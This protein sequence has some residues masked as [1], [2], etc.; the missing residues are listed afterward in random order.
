[1]KVSYFGSPKRCH[2]CGTGEYVEVLTP[3][4]PSSS[5]P[6][7]K[8]YPILSHETVRAVWWMHGPCW[9][10]HLRDASEGDPALFFGTGPASPED[11]TEDDYNIAEAYPSAAA[12]GLGDFLDVGLTRR[13]D[14]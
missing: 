13:R 11:A 9:L 8:N 7:G 6:P 12:E 4:P 1:M 5:D 14:A 3:G 10:A 2:W